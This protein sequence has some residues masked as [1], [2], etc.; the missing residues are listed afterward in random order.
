MLAWPQRKIHECCSLILYLVA[1]GKQA[2]KDLG[3]F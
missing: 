1:E 2:G 3:P